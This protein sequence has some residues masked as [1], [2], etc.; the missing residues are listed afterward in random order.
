MTTTY[1]ITLDARRRPT[2][3]AELLAESG[4]DPR[5]ELVAYAEE[6]RIVLS[7]R[8]ALVARVQRVFGEASALRGVDGAAL[9]Q[10]Q[11]AEDVAVEEARLAALEER[12]GQASP[13]R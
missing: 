9:L 8:A 5:D 1:P 6:G 13:G 2:L 10:A 4:L 7:T 12:A 11:R 3:P